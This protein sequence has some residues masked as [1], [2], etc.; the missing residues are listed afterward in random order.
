M[1]N[2]SKKRKGGTRDEIQITETAHENE[3]ISRSTTTTRNHVAT[4]NETEDEGGPKTLPERREIEDSPVELSADLTAENACKGKSL[5]ILQVNC[6][7]IYNKVLEFWNL[8]EIYN[9][10]VIIGTESWLHQEINNAEVFRGDYITFRRDRCSRG[11]GGVF[12]CVK[13]HIVCRELWTDEEFEMLAVEIK[14]RNQKLTW[15]IVGMY[16]APNEDMQVLERLV[17]RTEG[18]SNTAKCSIIGGDLNLP[19]VDWNGKAEGKN[20]TALINRLVWVNGFSQVIERPT[21]GTLYWTC[22]WFDL[23]V[24]SPLAAQYRG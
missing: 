5:V 12:I 13:N 8:I 15:E 18:T 7:S 22:T 24:H 9:P 14:S 16:R 23:K 10:D 11:G 19:Q 1:D 6:R 3:G 4:D 17:A 2:A 20:L 21:R